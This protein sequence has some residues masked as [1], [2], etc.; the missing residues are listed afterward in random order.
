[1]A[2]SGTPSDVIVVG[3]IGAPFGV[4]GWVHVRS[5]TDP[6]AN[7]LGYSPWLLKHPQGWRQC[8][9]AAAKPHGQGLVAQFAGVA[10]R[11]AAA[12]LT[13]TEVAVSRDSLPQLPTDEYYWQELVGLHV[14]AMQ[15]Q[16]LGVVEE[17]MDLGV[18]VVLVVRDGNVEHLIPFV[19]RHV[20]QVDLA[21]G[22]VTVDWQDPE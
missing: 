14:V 4:R 3:A 22:R 21:G 5:F 6:P 20:L 7:L 17:I 12:A 9:P 13:R 15:G 19:A 8:H 16:Q 1:M 10:D 18:H 11:D 2:L